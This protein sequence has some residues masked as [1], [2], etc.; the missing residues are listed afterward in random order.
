M[1]IASG[2]KCQGSILG[3]PKAV[4]SPAS[5]VSVPTGNL[6]VL[7]LRCNLPVLLRTPGRVHPFLL[8]LCVLLC[9]SLKKVTHRPGN[10]YECG[11]CHLNMCVSCM[12]PPSPPAPCPSPT[13]SPQQHVSLPPL[14]P[15]DRTKMGSPEETGQWGRLRPPKLVQSAE[16]G[17]GKDKKKRER[18]I[19]V[20]RRPCQKII[21]QLHTPVCTSQC[22]S[23]QTQHGLRVYIWMHLVNGT[24]NSPSLG[25]PTPE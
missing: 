23:W 15:Q 22:W 9:M 1:L 4:P 7:C 3:E 25:Q 13:P 10:I 8:H 21:L 2:G 5:V 17:K 12:P 18:I 11:T 6:T 14:T 24:G 20:V 19:T 16:G